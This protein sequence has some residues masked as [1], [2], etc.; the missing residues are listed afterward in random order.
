MTKLCQSCKQDKP[1]DA[2][3]LDRR[4]KDG[5][6]CYCRS[7]M[8]QKRKAITRAQW[9]TYQNRWRESNRD[10]TRAKDRERYAADPEKAKAAQQRYRSKHPDKVASQRRAVTLARYG[11]THAEYQRLLE[12]QGGGCAICRSNDPHHWSRRFQV[13]HDHKTGAVRGLLC[14]GCNGGLGLFK[15]DLERLRAAIHY[16]ASAEGKGPAQIATAGFFRAS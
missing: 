13:D 1:L 7:C 10:H 5:R 16:I 14:S 4:R 8:V 12:K 2:F 6:L 3:C 9:Q 11:L 15:D